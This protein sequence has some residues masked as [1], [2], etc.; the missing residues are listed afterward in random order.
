[1]VGLVV[2]QIT[3]ALCY[4]TCFLLSGNVQ[5]CLAWLPKKTP[6]RLLH[7]GCVFRALQKKIATDNAYVARFCAR[8]TG[9]KTLHDPLSPLPNPQPIS[10]SKFPEMSDM[11]SRFPS[12]VLFQKLSYSSYETSFSSK[13]RNLSRYA[14]LVFARLARAEMPEEVG[15]YSWLRCFQNDG[16]SNNGVSVL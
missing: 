12:K 1:M 14:L 8:T 7:G 9:Y 2:P 6:P 4:E 11:P 10:T 5:S 3:A 13:N 15:Q 16:T